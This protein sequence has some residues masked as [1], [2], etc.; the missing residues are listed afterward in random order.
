MTV[1]RYISD[2]GQ[3]EAMLGDNGDVASASVLIGGSMT[4]RFVPII[5]AGKWNKKGVDEA[6]LSI[7]RKNIIVSKGEFG[8]FRDGRMELIIGNSRDTYY[9]TPD[10]HL[11]YEISFTDKVPVS[12]DLELS[13]PPGMEFWKQLVLTEDDIKDGKYRPENVVN[14]YIFQWCKRNNQYKAGIFG[15]LY[16][17]FLKDDN[18]NKVW[19]DQ[20]IDGNVLRII[21][22]NEEWLKSVTYPI[23]IGP[24]L[25]YD[26]IGSSGISS[27]S[28]RVFYSRDEATATGTVVSFH[29]ALTET[30]TPSVKMGLFADSAGPVPGVLLEQVEFAVSSSDDENT[31]SID[32]DPITATVK[33]WIGIICSTNSVVLKYNDVA[34]IDRSKTGTTYGAELTD[35][36]VS[37]GGTGITVSQWIIHTEA[38]V[39]GIVPLLAAGM[40]NNM[41]SSANLMTG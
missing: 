6:W 4:D 27:N 39:G 12:I 25:G 26:T 13:F 11:E 33:Y 19:C 14:A 30:G 36:A 24:T 34:I 15:Q 22:G 8:T 16:R 38:A 18:N 10:G 1:L 35:P 20:E 37:T 21:P 5:Y 17:P 31:L 2:K 32:Q 28:Q 40:G 29:V 3:T 9:T 7:N 23:T 41:G